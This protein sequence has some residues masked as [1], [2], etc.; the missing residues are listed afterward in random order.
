[1]KS[2]QASVYEIDEKPVMDVIGEM[3]EGLKG[4]FLKD[5]A[6]ARKY[7]ETHAVDFILAEG[8]TLE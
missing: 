4:V 1:M 8:G 7:L 2:F 5:K 3:G 6:R